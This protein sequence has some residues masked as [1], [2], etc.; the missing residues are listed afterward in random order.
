[1]RPLI[2][3]LYDGAKEARLTMDITFEDGRKSTLTST[4][5]STTSRRG[6]RGQ[7]DGGVRRASGAHG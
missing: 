6:A 3:A 4:L 5:P 2:A 7:A 1:M